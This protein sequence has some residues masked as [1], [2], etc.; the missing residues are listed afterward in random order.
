MF[1]VV[2]MAFWAVAMALKCGCE[3]DPEGSFGILR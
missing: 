2:A 1:A 3:D